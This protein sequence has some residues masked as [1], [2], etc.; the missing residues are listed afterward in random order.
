MN[1]KPS[2]L[3]FVNLF[4]I[5]TISV[6]LF[7][8]QSTNSKVVVVKSEQLF[9]GFRMTKEIKKK[10]DF[11]IQS[12]NKKLDSLQ[13]E[14]SRSNN[15]VLRNNLINQ[16]NQQRQ[17]ILDFNNQFVNQETKKI[18]SRIND[19]VEI[20]GKDKGFSIII[21]AQTSGNI[22]YAENA[23]DITSD[24]LNYINKQYEGSN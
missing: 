9:N 10:G 7:N 20:Y 8:F 17:D 13:L 15:V 11:I 2:I 23:K 22:Y 24:L 4:L 21:G 5:L 1:Y 12:F 16:I 14:L 3:S 19:Y 6:L 18:W